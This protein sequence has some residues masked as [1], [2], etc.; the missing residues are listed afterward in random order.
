MNNH[1]RSFEIRVVSE[2]G[3]PFSVQLDNRPLVIG[4]SKQAGLHLDA[5]FVSRRHALI[6]QHHNQVQIIDLGSKN[7]TYLNGFRLSPNKKQ[8]WQPGDTL[9][10]GSTRLELVGAPV[11]N[12]MP[13][14]VFNLTIARPSLSPLTPASLKLNYEGATTQ[15]VYFEGF[16]LDQGVSFRL[17]PSEA[18]VEP[19]SQDR[20]SG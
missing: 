5:R 1:S 11:F 19:G 13:D 9:T 14:G 17:D 7:G 4:S 10:L 6:T 18:Y 8:D 3:D 15:Q 12:H 2:Q 20:G 16:A